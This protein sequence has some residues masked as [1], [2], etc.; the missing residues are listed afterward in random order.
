MGIDWSGRSNFRDDG[1]QGIE[2]NIIDNLWYKLH[3][4][5]GT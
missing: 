2:G 4:D 3:L 5:K 1:W